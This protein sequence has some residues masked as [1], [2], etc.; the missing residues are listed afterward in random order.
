MKPQLYK[1]GGKGVR[2]QGRKGKEESQADGGGKGDGPRAEGNPIK[3]WED[4][5]LG[6]AF[7]NR[8]E[9]TSTQHFNTATLSPAAARSGQLCLS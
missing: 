2:G 1:G 8:R 3:L 5:T 9:L 7:H 4:Q 6:S